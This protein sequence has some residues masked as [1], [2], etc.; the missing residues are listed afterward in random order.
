MRLG[1]GSGGGGCGRYS[2]I[3]RSAHCAILSSAVSGI[4]CE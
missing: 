1:T 2:S 4:L 3:L